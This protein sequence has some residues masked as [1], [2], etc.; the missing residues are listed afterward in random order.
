MIMDGYEKII[1][2]MQKAGKFYNAPSPCIGVIEQ[3][4]KIKIGSLTLEKDEYLLD[5]NLRLE[6]SDKMYFYTK[7]SG[8]GH[9]EILKEYT[10]NILKEGDK[11]LMTKL[12][13]IPGEE[14]EKYIVIAKVVVPE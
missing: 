2:I 3:E 10:R 1:E 6:S 8:T 7:E 12:Q 13:S 11:V 14:T 4:G 9:D 5:C